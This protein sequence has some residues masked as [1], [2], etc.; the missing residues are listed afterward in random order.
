M[1]S[2]ETPDANARLL[3]Y[4]P[5]TSQH[6]ITNQPPETLLPTDTL[7]HKASIFL[8]LLRMTPGMLPNKEIPSFTQ[9]TLQAPTRNWS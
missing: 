1:Q 7:W 5:L 9:W 8:F 2:L 4:R 6:H 3:V